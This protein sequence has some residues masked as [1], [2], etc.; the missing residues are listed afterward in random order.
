SRKILRRIPSFSLMTPIDQKL[1]RVHHPK[2]TL[3][4]AFFT[5]PSGSPGDHGDEGKAATAPARPDIPCG[6]SSEKRRRHE[7][8]PSCTALVRIWPGHGRAWRGHTT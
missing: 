1:A 6:G 2:E 4:G 7:D 3:I 5:A 8:P